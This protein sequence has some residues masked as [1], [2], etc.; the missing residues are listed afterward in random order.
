[1]VLGGMRVKSSAPE[2]VGKSS[3]AKGTGAPCDRVPIPAGHPVLAKLPVVDEPH[4]NELVN[5][6]FLSATAEV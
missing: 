5:G 6:G 1:M 2:T 4:V 3:G